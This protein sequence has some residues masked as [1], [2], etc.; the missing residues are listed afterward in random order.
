MFT[1]KY[2]DRFVARFVDENYMLMIFHSTM[3][4]N[5]NRIVY[6]ILKIQEPKCFAFT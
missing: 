6:T 3:W 1:M 5:S 2:C 4:K